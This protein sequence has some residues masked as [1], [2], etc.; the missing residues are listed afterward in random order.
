MQQICGYLVVRK[1]E[2]TKTHLPRN[3]RIDGKEYYGIARRAWEDFEVAYY[4]RRLPAELLPVW[5]DLERDTSDFSGV[6]LLKCYAQASDV[7]DFSGDKSEIIAFWS[8]ELAK[9]KGTIDAAVALEYLGLDCCSEWSVLCN[10][11]FWR[12]EHFTETVPQLNR[13]GL[14]ASEAECKR[15]FDRYLHLSA[16]EIVEPMMEDPPMTCISV[17]RVPQ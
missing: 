1:P 6:K 11:V 12:P 9:I 13:W 7:L 2:W 10:G 4:D 8:A 14:L 16:T 17:F 15:A 5:Q 3:P